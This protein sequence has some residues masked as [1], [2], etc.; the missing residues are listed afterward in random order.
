MI[1]NVI[2]CVAPS[3]HPKRKSKI[4]KSIELKK[5]EKIVK[6]PTIELIDDRIKLDKTIKNIYSI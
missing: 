5:N 2:M 4:P 1:M 6:Y 3:L